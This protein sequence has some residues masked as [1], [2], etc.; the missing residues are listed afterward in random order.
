M[1]CEQKG[2]QPKEATLV[3]M[4]AL[5]PG[6]VFVSNISDVEIEHQH[7][8]HHRG[9]LIERS[10]S[11]YFNEVLEICLF[12]FLKHLLR[13]CGFPLRV[14]IVLKALALNANQNAPLAIELPNL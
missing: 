4:N 9:F 10:A 5:E 3:C 12:Q 6:Q 7:Q 2:F 8:E 1:P 14:A 11:A 13:P